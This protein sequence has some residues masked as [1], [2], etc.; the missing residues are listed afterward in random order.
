MR[1]IFMTGSVAAAILA[2][3]LLAVQA[4]PVSV[5]PVGLIPIEN[6]A[7]CFY[8]DG[9]RGP[10]MYECGFRTRHGRGWVGERR[11]EHREFRRED[12]RGDRRDDRRDDRRR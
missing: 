7:V 4:M 10:G 12:R 9:W 8:V 1:H 5:P 6:V 11:V 3:S 2:S